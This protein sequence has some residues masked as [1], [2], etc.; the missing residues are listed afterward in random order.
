MTIRLSTDERSRLRFCRWA[1]F[2]VAPAAPALIA[3]TLIAVADKLGYHDRRGFDGGCLY[4][5]WLLAPP[6]AAAA[7]F[8]LHP[9][10]KGR[11][12]KAIVAFFAAVP[13]YWLAFAVFA[14]AGMFVGF[15]M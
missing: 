10:T 1:T 12:W 3:F 7:M 4:G 2:L 9:V 15:D 13:I 14:I 6:L 5:N 11:W 8:G